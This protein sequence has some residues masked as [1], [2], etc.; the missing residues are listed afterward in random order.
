MEL[1][2]EEI[3]KAKIKLVTLSEINEWVTKK[4]YGEA[5]PVNWVK[6]IQLYFKLKKERIDKERERLK[7]L[8]N[9]YRDAYRCL[10]LLIQ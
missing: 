5:L 10:E 2:E 7:K 4:Y 8:E 6:Q 1:T 9:N 3:K